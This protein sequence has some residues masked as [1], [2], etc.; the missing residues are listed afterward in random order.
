MWLGF[1]VVVTESTGF[2]GYN[3]A[4]AACRLVVWQK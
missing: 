3:M 2:C 1:I 4:L